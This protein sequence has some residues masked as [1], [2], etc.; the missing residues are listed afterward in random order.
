MKV[1]IANSVGV[2][3]CGDHIVHFPSRWTA[4]V[5]KVKCF[6]YYPYELAYLSS[7]L[8]RETN[9]EVKLVDGNLLQLNAE[10]YIKLLEKEQ[11]DWLVMETSTI[12]FNEDLKVA[13][14]IKE[15]CG[16]RLIFTGQHPTAYPAEVLAE[17]VDYVCIGEY[18]YTVLDILDGKDPKDILGLYPNSRRHLL[19]INQ[20]PFPEDNDISRWDYIGIGGSEYKEIEMFASRGCKMSCVFCVCRHLYYAKPNWRGRHI[21]SIIDEIEYLRSKYPQMEGIFFDEEEHNAEKKFIIDLTKAIREKG[22]DD[23]KYNAMCGYWTLDREMIETMYSA[24]YYKLRIGIETASEIV[25][26]AI[27]KKI[28][29]PRLKYILRMAKDVGMK[30]YGTFTF[31]APGATR[32]EDMKTVRLIE[33]LVEKDLLC[34]LQISICTPQP[35]TPFYNWAKEKG[36]LISDNWQDYDGTT[37][38]VVGYP[39]YSN[40]EIE[41]VF[42][43][44]VQ[45]YGWAFRNRE[46]RKGDIGKVIREK[47]SQYGIF[48]TLQ[49]G[50]NKIG[51]DRKIKLQ[52][53]RPFQK[54]CGEKPHSSLSEKE[55]E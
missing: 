37:C 54:R 19:D 18:E 34:D 8:K 5:G 26:K 55:C 13:K 53:K 15:K 51:T 25:A 20:L 33:E 45:V 4:S 32:K 27:R 22:L 9:Y 42:H 39:N 17:N 46:I 49:R 3:E 16:S 24:G 41:E 1:I 7:L 2:D 50:L 30:M 31:G 38:A 44:A 28:D 40:K 14:A 35:G 6:T 36:H 29:V 11:P 21:K 47:V 52:L 23:L 10:A 43:L 12:V 48:G